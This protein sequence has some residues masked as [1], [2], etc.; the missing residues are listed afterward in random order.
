MKKIYFFQTS[1]T[2]TSRNVDTVR[3]LVD[4][5]ETP[6]VAIEMKNVG[7]GKKTSN[8]GN[9]GVVNE[10]QNFASKL[11]KPGKSRKSKTAFELL[12]FRGPILSKRIQCK[13]MLH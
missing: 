10:R 4:A 5:N 1:E 12:C 3:H 7:G 6:V 9:V 13:L 8:V 2:E 11:P